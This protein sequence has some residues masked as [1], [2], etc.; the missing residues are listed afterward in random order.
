MRHE[1][2]QKLFADHVYLSYRNQGGSRKLVG[3]IGLVT[4]FVDD[5]R[6]RWTASDKAR[7][8]DNLNH[9]LYQLRLEANVRHVPLRFSCEFLDATL[10]MDC[11]K[12]N[13]D[14][15]SVQSL[16]QNT[17]L[18]ESVFNYQKRYKETHQVDEAPILFAFNRPLRSW[19]RN[20]NW[21]YQGEYSMVNSDDAPED[22][23]HELLHQFGA[24][25]FYYPK[26]VS[27]LL[28]KMGYFSVMHSRVI[29]CVDSLTAYLIGW[30]EEID[31]KAVQI[32]QKTKH[33]TEEM[34]YQFIHEEWR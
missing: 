32:L 12:D 22:L 3:H 4:V 1:E 14:E 31:E 19:A 33:Y 24:C 7:F 23:M 13:K 30:T 34:F 11:T 15:W 28:T 10:A 21:L 20:T 8:K 25:D 17:G 18:W 5:N 2:I 26:E 16:K 9:G 6:S 27:V 29:F